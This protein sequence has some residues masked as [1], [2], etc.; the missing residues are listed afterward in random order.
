MGTR[1]WLGGATA[2][3][4]AWSGTVTDAT[5]GSTYTLT[6]TSESGTTGTVVYTVGGG[7]TTTTVAAGIA[8][9]VNASTDP[10][11]TGVV[12]ASSSAAIVTVLAR[13]AG[14]PFYLAATGGGTG[15]GAWSGTGNTTPNI[16]P[17]DWNWRGNWADLTVPVATDDVV[18]TG[19]NAIKYGLDQSGV[20]LHGFTRAYGSS[21]AIGGP[22]KYLKLNLTGYADYGTG[23]A[24]VDCGSSS[25]SPLVAA[26]QGTIAAPNVFFLGSAIG[27]LTANAGGVEVAGAVGQTST[28]GTAIVNG[29]NVR[30][31]P[32]VTLTTYRQASGSG[33]VDCAATTVQ[34]DGGTL[35]TSGTGA[36]GTLTCG[37]A[38]V[39]AN[40]TGT[41]TTLI[42]SKGA[43]DF[44]QSDATRTVTTPTLSGT[45]KILVD[46]AVVTFTNKLAISGRVS[47][48][49]AAA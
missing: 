21:A 17:N 39:T 5:S 2:V 6:F 31:G 34:A 29:G 26:G 27:T 12:F 14:V 48:T 40:S 43:V 47:V 11:V 38:N 35:L 41:V 16:G 37:G 33:Q 30:L 9:A 24:Y 32:G 45:G 1:Y 19:G 10:R 28:V 36:I 8:A 4:Q 44:T 7:A 46:S 22:G 23:Q 49:A 25:V 3:Q 20:A 15:P 42:C 13:A 18:I